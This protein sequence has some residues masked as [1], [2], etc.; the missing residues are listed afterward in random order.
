[1]PDLTISFDHL[2]IVS[3]KKAPKI[4]HEFQELGLEMQGF[5][6]KK[7]WPRIWTLFYKKGYTE[8][9]IRYALKECQKR[10]KCSVSYLEAIVRNCKL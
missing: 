3:Q 10:G 5:F 2:P 7:E 9:K 4:E 1:M 8:R 6:E